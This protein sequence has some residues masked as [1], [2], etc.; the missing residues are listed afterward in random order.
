MAA[1]ASFAHKGTADIGEINGQGV[2]SNLERVLSTCGLSPHK[3]RKKI[4]GD[5]GKFGQVPAPSVEATKMKYYIGFVVTMIVLIASMSAVEVYKWIKSPHVKIV[6]E[7][8]DDDVSDV[9]SVAKPVV[10]FA[11]LMSNIRQDCSIAD[12]VERDDLLSADFSELV[13]AVHRFSFRASDPECFLKLKHTGGQVYADTYNRWDPDQM[14]SPRNLHFTLG[15]PGRKTDY[16][17]PNNSIWMI[18]ESS[19][20]WSSTIASLQRLDAS[21]DERIWISTIAGWDGTVMAKM[22][23]M[24]PLACK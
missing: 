8:P 2:F 19:S 16:C 1:R 13:V 3:S 17:L 24:H 9:K 14:A 6:T 18:T 21:Q 4:F 11:A 20:K 23:G 10:D 15:Y 22:A 5:A 7:I 12:D